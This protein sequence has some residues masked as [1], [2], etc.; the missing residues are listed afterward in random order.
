MIFDDG[1]ASRPLLEDAVKFALIEGLHG[2]ANAARVRL[3]KKV[4]S[5]GV[6]KIM[7]DTVF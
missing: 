5:S 6:I 3:R 2:H 4:V 7:N 1:A